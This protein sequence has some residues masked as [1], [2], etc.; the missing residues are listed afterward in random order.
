MQSRAW[1]SSAVSL[2]WGLYAGP[3][4]S[5]DVISQR[6]VSCTSVTQT[7]AYCTMYTVVTTVKKEPVS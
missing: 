1:L 2:S 5:Q 4:P 6:A 7:L 3:P